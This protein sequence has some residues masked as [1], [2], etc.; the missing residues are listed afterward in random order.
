[1][2]SWWSLKMYIIS[3]F[4]KYSDTLVLKAPSRENILYFIQIKPILEQQSHWVFTP[5]FC[6][7]KLKPTC[8][9]PGVGW[10]CLLSL[11]LKIYFSFVKL[12]KYQS[13]YG[14]LLRVLFE[15]NSFYLD[16]LKL[17]NFTSDDKQNYGEKSSNII[18]V[19]YCYILY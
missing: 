14:F 5:I 13:D 9:V 6:I 10:T 11:Q 4:V 16:N 12:I 7:F 19:H 3:S 15:V 17:K 8:D 18:C 2:N 1:M